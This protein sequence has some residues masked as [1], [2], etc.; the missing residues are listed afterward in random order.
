MPYRIKAQSERGHTVTRMDLDYTHEPIMD[1][2]Y[3]QQLADDFA[4]TRP[5][6]ANGKNWRGIVE[7]YETSIANPLWDR[8][9]GTVRNPYDKKK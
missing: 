5:H 3:A 2:A 6:G 8:S 1:R 4:A 9:N 7:H